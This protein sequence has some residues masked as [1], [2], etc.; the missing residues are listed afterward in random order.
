MMPMQLTLAWLEQRV[1]PLGFDVQQL[2]LEQWRGLH[3]SLH[4]A[5]AVEISAEIRKA[6]ESWRC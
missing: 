4:R 2:P 6:M 5:T 1:T 3:H